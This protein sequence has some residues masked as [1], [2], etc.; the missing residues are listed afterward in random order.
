MLATCSSSASFASRLLKGKHILSSLT[1]TMQRAHFWHLR[2]TVCCSAN[3]LPHKVKSAPLEV[4]ISIPLLERLGDPLTPVNCFNVIYYQANVC[5]TFH[6]HPCSNQLPVR[7]C[8]SISWSRNI[9]EFALFSAWWGAT[10]QCRF[11][12]HRTVD[13]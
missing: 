7:S 10:C 9:I 2:C 5:I 1:E 8:I 13:I 6:W 4:T 12:A 3:H 11:R